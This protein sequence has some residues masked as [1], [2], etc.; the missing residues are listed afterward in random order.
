MLGT[1]SMYPSASHRLPTPSETI[2][3]YGN[4]KIR[5]RV[6][7]FTMFQLPKGL[8]RSCSNGMPKVLATYL[9][10]S[11]KEEFCVPIHGCI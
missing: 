4:N 1:F 6:D 3:N 11:T 9:Q 10:H 8:L 5:L 7:T 2:V